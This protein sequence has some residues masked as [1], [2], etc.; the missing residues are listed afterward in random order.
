MHDWGFSVVLIIFLRR[1]K[2]IFSK[3]F[4]L[5]ILLSFYPPTKFLSDNS[6]KHQMYLS[7]RWSLGNKLVA[8]KR[9]E[10]RSNLWMQR[11]QLRSVLCGFCVEF[12]DIDSEWPKLNC[13][14]TLAPIAFLVIIK[15]QNQDPFNVWFV[16]TW[17]KHHH[18]CCDIFF[19]ALVHW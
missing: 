11:L 6:V 2:L 13:C 1:A 5:A 14:F 7:W 3:H 10:T 9:W 19:D 18:Q 4:L 8:G 17:M 15:F 16:Y 12:D